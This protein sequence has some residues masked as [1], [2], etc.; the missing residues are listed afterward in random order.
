MYSQVKKWYN[1]CNLRPLSEK[2]HS[3]K[4]TGCKAALKNGLETFPPLP[5]RPSRFQKRENFLEKGEGNKIVTISIIEVGGRK[6]PVL[7]QPSE[8]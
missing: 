1:T 2:S 5:G 3:F 6:C 8:G 7:P 4:I